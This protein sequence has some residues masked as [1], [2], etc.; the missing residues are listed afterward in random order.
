ML[1]AKYL[2]P[3]LLLLASIVLVL[4]S[5]C[6]APTVE[7]EIGEEAR[8]GSISEPVEESAEELP[9]EE[10]YSGMEIVV[11]GSGHMYGPLPVIFYALTALDGMDIYPLG[12]GAFS[13]FALYDSG[14]T[15]VRINNL[16][17]PNRV[18][19]S[20]WDNSDAGHLKI[21]GVETVNL[22]LNG[23]NERRSDGSIPMGPPE[24]GN[25]AQVDVPKVAVMPEEVDVSLIG[26]PVVN[27]LIAVIDYTALLTDPAIEYVG[28]G[29]YPPTV[30]L[31]WPNEVKPTPGLSL[32]LEPFGNLVSADA[33]PGYRYWLRDIDFHH[34]NSVANDLLREFNYLFDTGTT[35]TIISDQVA[36]VLQLSSAEADFDCFGK[37]GAGHYLD[38]VT[39]YGVDGRYTVKNAAVCW[40]Q[41]KIGT[42]DAVIGSNFFDQ[43][44][45]IVD[46]P[47]NMLG[48]SE[49]GKEVV[50][51]Q[52][53]EKPPE[54][55]APPVEQP[56]EVQPPRVD[57]P[58]G[59]FEGVVMEQGTGRKIEGAV[60]SFVSEDGSVKK[61]VQSGQ[62]GYYQVEL[63]ISRYTVSAW[64]DDYLPFSTGSGFYIVPSSQLQYGDITMEPKP[65]P[66]DIPV[67][68]FQG[69][70]VD[71]ASGAGIAGALIIFEREDGAYRQDTQSD[72]SGNYQINLPAGRFW[73]TASHGDY[74]TYS[75]RPGFFVLPGPGMQV[76]NI[77]MKPKQGSSGGTTGCGGVQVGGFCW[78]FGADS[79]SC[80]D[81]CSSHGGYHDATRSFAGSDG[82]PVSCR[83]VLDAMGLVVDDFYET[84][85]GGIGCF[86][87]RNTKGNYIGYWDDV[88][89]TSSG[90]YGVPGRQR[91]CACQQ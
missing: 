79:A 66:E 34:G 4:V 30:N 39:M 10:P 16:F 88:P 11:D 41:D 78:Y 54:A 57:L 85:Q 8:E 83:N 3:V 22:R 77:F 52:E 23:V 31:Y 60:I 26:A 9:A 6:A 86:A 67:G 5:A 1:Q 44:Q 40:A 32:K 35:M 17:P 46:G 80:D 69:V 75:T 48:I 90:T 71:S 72:A 76:G 25:E 84:K 12:D 24:S 27:Q 63:P 49:A 2:Y 82:S 38:S 87:L 64:H 58:P 13:L 68:G 20:N 36:N 43:V 55:E 73:V 70:V 51:H 47:G 33:T 21:S 65:K 7:P 14:S 45:I 18:S 61:E 56:K 91:I 81:V 62:N 50:I 74:E 59:G 28:T 37:A 29:V 42:G 53:A 15:K 89:T 19:G